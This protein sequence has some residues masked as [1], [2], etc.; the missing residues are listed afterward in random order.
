MATEKQ[1]IKQWI[2]K[3]LVDSKDIP[4]EELQALRRIGDTIVHNGG[5]RGDIS[6]AWRKRGWTTANIPDLY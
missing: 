3:S 1:E 2:V 5:F 6:D 4:G